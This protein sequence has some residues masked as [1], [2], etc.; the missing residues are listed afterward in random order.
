[1]KLQLTA[2]ALLLL[3]S[4]AWAQSD[5]LNGQTPEQVIEQY[6]SDAAPPF[7]AP[8]L[9]IGDN[10]PELGVTEFVKGA[11]VGSFENGNVYLIDFW[12][13]WCGPCIRSMPHLSELQEK[14]SGEGLQVVAVDIWENKRTA[15]GSEP[16]VGDERTELVKE[17]VKKHDEN[18]RYTVA[19]DGEQMLEEHWMKAAGQRGIPTA[20]IIDRAGKVAWIGYG[21]DS[22]MGESLDAI[23]AGKHDLKAM[24]AER[25]EAMRKEH[26]GQRAGRLIGTANSMLREGEEK[27]AL[28]LMAALSAAD[29]KD[30][31]MGLNAMAWN[32]VDREEVSTKSAELARDMAAKA[33]KLTEW[34]DSNILD[35]LAWA[36]H[37]LG[38][39]AKAIEIETKAVKHSTS[40]DQREAMEEVLAKFKKAS[41]GH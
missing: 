2:S 38:E 35:T 36:H 21:T 41:G 26:D 23:L 18:M 11:P 3:T 14:H 12:A 4:P 39:H 5:Y 31:A 15:N 1:M 27:D 28:S 22:S 9:N 6:A 13:T 8:K 30:D 17:F 10:A 33:C 19:I 25:L 24:R 37:H 32:L 20:M 34:E 29:F 40:D 16:I 7:V